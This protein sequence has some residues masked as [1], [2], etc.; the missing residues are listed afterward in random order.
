MGIK[1]EKLGPGISCSLLMNEDFS[2]PVSGDVLILLGWTGGSD[3]LL[4]KAYADKYVAAGFHVFTFLAPVPPLSGRAANTVFGKVVSSKSW[5]S[6]FDPATSPPRKV[7][8]HVF[9]NGGGINLSHLLRVTRNSAVPL[10]SALTTIIFDSVPGVNSIQNHAEFTM[11]TT[12]P[13]AG[14][15]PEGGADPAIRTPFVVATTYAKTVPWFISTELD[16]T[17]WKFKNMLGFAG[18]EEDRPFWIAVYKVFLET[19]YP[20]LKNVLFLFSKR[21]R[22]TD[23][24]A[25]EA[26]QE[27]MQKALRDTFKRSTVVSG[28]C[29]EDSEHVAHAS[30]YGSEYWAQVARVLSEAGFR[31]SEIIGRNAAAKAKL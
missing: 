6:V 27:G 14:L 12:L 18:D 29:F 7:V 31:G 26:A 9:S 2:A 17:W 4:Q 10:V 23:Y 1:H 25:V 11:S 3:K 21:D 30:K 19:D 8:A 28:R 15:L 5:T 22:L 16:L 24:R 13:R 20:N